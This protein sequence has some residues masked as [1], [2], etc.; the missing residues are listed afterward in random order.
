MIRAADYIEGL[1]LDV[2]EDTCIQASDDVRELRLIRC[3]VGVKVVTGRLSLPVEDVVSHWRAAVLRVRGPS[4]CDLCL[5]RLRV[6]IDRRVGLAW[7]IRSYRQVSR[8]GIRE[9]D[10]VVSL[11]LELV[12]VSLRKA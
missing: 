10:A 9:A 6:I 11:Y 2:V 5:V 12:V 7:R 4:D 3:R 8:G 1:D